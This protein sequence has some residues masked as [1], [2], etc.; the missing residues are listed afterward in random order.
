LFDGT[1]SI[2]SRAKAA[3][4][5]KEI[6]ESKLNNYGAL[7]VEVALFRTNVKYFSGGREGNVG[8]FNDDF[9]DPLGLLK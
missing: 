5:I 9:Y 4:G 1:G 7:T 3:Q 8:L 6:I 2:S